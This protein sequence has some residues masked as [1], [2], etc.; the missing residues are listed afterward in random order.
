MLLKKEL[1]KLVKKRQG[2]SNTGKI[3][4]RHRGGGAKQRSRKIEFTKTLKDI[5]GIVK[6]FEYDPKRNVKL[7]VI[8]YSNGIK[9]YIL[10]PKELNIGDKIIFSDFIKILPGNSTYIKNIPLGTKIH[11]LESKPKGGAKYI[12]SGGCEGII[13]SQ[14]GKYFIIKLPSNEIKL[15]H[16]N[17]IASIGVL[18]IT[19]KSIFTNAGRNRRLGKR[20]TVRGSAMNACDHPHGGGE[21][22]APIGRKSPVTPWGKKTLGKKT[23]LNKKNIKY[24]TIK[25]V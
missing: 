25:T 15:F 21:G 13:L 5:Y 22:K 11:N 12:R 24:S 17:C 2:R 9:R 10:K 3:T 14:T 16:G 6:S 4:V 19:K 1:D 8:F 23:V 18:D 7:A 20:P